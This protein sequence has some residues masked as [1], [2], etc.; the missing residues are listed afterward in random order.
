M[1]LMSLEQQDDFRRI[2]KH[3]AALG[4][5]LKLDPDDPLTISVKQAVNAKQC[6]QRIYAMFSEQQDD[7]V[8]EHYESEYACHKT[9]RDYHCN[10]S[11]IELKTTTQPV[12]HEQQA[13]EQQP[14]R[15]P[16]QHSLF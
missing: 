7:G 6:G 2:V 14:K 12:Q 11:W 1:N 8:F 13:V 16:V 10:G 4:C 5:R 15:E 9:H 3:I